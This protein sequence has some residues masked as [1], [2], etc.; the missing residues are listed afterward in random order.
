MV[1]VF[2]F[3]HGGYIHIELMCHNSKKKN[4]VNIVFF[5][6][7]LIIYCNVCVKNDIATEIHVFYN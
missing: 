3:F 5:I 2:A 1:F 4:T 6:L 7:L